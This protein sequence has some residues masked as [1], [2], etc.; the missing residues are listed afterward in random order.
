MTVENMLKYNDDL[1]KDEVVIITEMDCD[2]TAM[3]LP[4]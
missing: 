2:Q 1:P 3:G 4:P